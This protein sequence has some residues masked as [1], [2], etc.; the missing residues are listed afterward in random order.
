MFEKQHLS[1][2]LIVEK[3]LK[4]IEQHYSFVKDLEQLE[5]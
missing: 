2:N 5:Q 1:E 4:I 3:D